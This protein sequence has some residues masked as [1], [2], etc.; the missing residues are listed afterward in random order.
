MFIAD[1]E[2][3]LDSLA[4]STLAESWDNVGLQV[5]DRGALVRRVLVALD[6]TP[7]VLDEAVA[8]G[9]DTIVTHHPIFFAPVRSLVDSSPRER[10]LRRVV[11]A[12]V[13][14]F[15]CHTNLDSAPG[16]LADVAAEALGLRNAKPLQLAPAGWYKLVG[17][18]PPDA[19]T[20]V[21]SAVFAAGAGVI[22][23]YS[24][25]AFALDGQGWFTPGPGS[26][27]TIGRL[28]QAERTPEVRWETV[29]PRMRL[30][31]V[32]QAYRDAHPYEEPAFDIYPVEDVLS[33]AGLGRVGEL[34]RVETVR[35][36]ARRIADRLS[37]PSLPWTGDGDRQVMR[38]AVVPGSGRSLIAQAAGRAEV[39][40]TGDVGYHDAQQAE[41]AGLALILAPH[42]G[43]EWYALRRWSVGLGK[44]LAGEGVD[45]ALSSRWQSPWSSGE[46][47]AKPAPASATLV[48]SASLVVS[49][50]PPDSAA[51]VVSATPPAGLRR[52]GA[53]QSWAQCHR[54][55]ART[56]RRHF[57]GGAGPFHRQGDQQHGRVPS[58]A[59]RARHGERARDHRTGGPLRLGTTRQADAGLLP[60]EERGAQATLR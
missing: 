37:L 22:G 28:Q 6:L 34:A 2:R 19:V 25:C 43:L 20:Q 42:E 44:T 35:S 59:G 57:V 31:A 51:L 48:D 11:A 54:R 40:V 3:V 36:L 15:A 13:N 60:G 12:G 50:T 21:A 24:D 4:P 16:G 1:L 18:I 58:L 53:G 5:G 30:N 55:G 23:T 10:L 45:L 49:A 9:F 29:V 46:A 27:P 32:M 33:R 56:R 47:S 26:E 8:A 39:L 52:G 14:V 17:F 41:E 7:P 38:V